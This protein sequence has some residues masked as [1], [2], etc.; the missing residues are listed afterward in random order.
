MKKLLG[1]GE[2]KVPKDQLRS[3]NSTDFEFNSRGAVT[4]AR[5]PHEGKAKAYGMTDAEAARNQ[6]RRLRAES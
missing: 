1:E 6:G 2:V 3:A 4:D 5:D